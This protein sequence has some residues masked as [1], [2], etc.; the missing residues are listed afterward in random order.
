M[1]IIYLLQHIFI[2]IHADYGNIYCIIASSCTTFT[3]NYKY[4][5]I[6]M[7][8]SC[9][10]SYLGNPAAKTSDREQVKTKKSKH[11]TKK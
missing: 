8:K 4:T 11:A 2:H 1:H 3:Y 5:R 7:H 9:I 6:V 10:N